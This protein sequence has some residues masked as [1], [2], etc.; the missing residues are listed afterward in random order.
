MD[1]MVFPMILA[2]PYPPEN[3]QNGVH[4]VNASH[5]RW[6]GPWRQHFDDESLRI[7]ACQWLRFFG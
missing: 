7:M 3:I 2:K 6:L 4:W 5:K 1:F